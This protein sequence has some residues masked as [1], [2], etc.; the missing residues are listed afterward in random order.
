METTEVDFLVNGAANF[1]GMDGL[2]AVLDGAFKADI[3]GANLTNFLKGCIDHAVK[4]PA[5]IKKCFKELAAPIKDNAQV[6]LD[7]FKLLKKFKENGCESKGGATPESARLGPPTDLISSKQ[8]YLKDGSTVTIT[9]DKQDIKHYKGRHTWKYFTMHVSN[10]PNAGDPT[11]MF[12][13][14]TDEGA[15]ISLAQGIIGSDDF[16]GLVNA[17]T[18]GQHKQINQSFGG[19]NYEYWIDLRGGKNGI[20][21]MYPK[22]GE[23]ID[24]DVLRI[25]I[26]LWN[27]LN[28]KEK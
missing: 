21:T 6:V 10:V 5:A 20:M 24:R 25:T 28:P 9:L 1:N 15:L 13:S 26:R 11:T 27:I 19:Q 2:A 16:E 3:N 8:M 7:A 18:I 14:G 12:P 17:M 22:D 4:D 23:Q